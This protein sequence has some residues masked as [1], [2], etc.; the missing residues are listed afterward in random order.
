MGAR[1]NQ[2][3]TMALGEADLCSVS[4]SSTKIEKQ[5]QGVNYR[6]QMEQLSREACTRS[7]CWEMSNTA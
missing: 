1:I 2:R 6:V 7:F 3:K 4:G 5:A